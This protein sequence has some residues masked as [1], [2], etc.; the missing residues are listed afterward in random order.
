[1]TLPCSQ[2]G[3]RYAFTDLGL[4]RHIIMGADPL[5]RPEP[6]AGSGENQRYVPSFVV[7]RHST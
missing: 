3:G 4:P 7:Q 6:P 2:S 1:M 5:K